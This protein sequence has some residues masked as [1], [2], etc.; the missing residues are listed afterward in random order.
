VCERER[1]TSVRGD[2]KSLK[3]WKLLGGLGVDG[4][5]LGF[6]EEDVGVE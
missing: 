5:K 3:G 6:K 1:E 2:Q 4:I